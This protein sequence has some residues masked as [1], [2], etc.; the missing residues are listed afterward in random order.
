[1]KILMVNGLHLGGVRTVVENVV[2][3][4]LDRRHDVSL[5]KGVDDDGKKLFEIEDHT[6]GR[7]RSRSVNIFKFRNARRTGNYHN[8]QIEKPFKEFLLS[9]KP[10]IVHFHSCSCIGASVIRVVR[11]LQIP[12]VVT[13]HDWWWICPR[14]Y[15]VDNRFEACAQGEVVR[16]EKCYCVVR[17]QFEVKR[18]QYLRKIVSRMPL[19]LVPSDHIRDSLIANG[20]DPDRLRVN[21]NGVHKPAEVPDKSS[22]QQLRFGFL[23]G[24]VG[25]KGGMVLLEA[26]HMIQSGNSI[27]KMFNFQRAS[28]IGES[29]DRMNLRETFLHV[30]RRFS[31]EPYDK[32]NQMKSLMKNRSLLKSAPHVSIQ[33][34][35]SYD[36]K[37]L[38]T[39]F[40]DLDVVVIPSIRES[41][42][43]IAR[44]AFMRNTPVICSTSGGPEEVVTDGVNGYVFEV[45]DAGQLAD[46]M[47]GLMTNP[48]KVDALRRNIDTQSI[49]GVD[50]QATMLEE[51]YRELAE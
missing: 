5:F 18:Y 27:L 6:E 30:Y 35:P 33:F 1:V 39:I 45:N 46:V 26:A 40:R 16:P 8:P 14:L 2:P 25:F 20:F 3:V 22:S 43:L 10:D 23:G 4:L 32:I 31:V 28:S 19:I 9:V 48:S 24:S 49:V 42:N 47:Q 21:P 12:Y 50:G 34:L 38:N 44:E 17:D 36:N 13:M 29:G 37:D 15:L 41:F 51:V 7:V 11:E